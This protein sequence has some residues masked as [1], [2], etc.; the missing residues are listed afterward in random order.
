MVA[1]MHLPHESA[2]TTG[3]RVRSAR[4]AAGLSREALAA[5][6]GVALRT[7]ARIELGEDMRLGTLTS[8]ARALDVSV[9]DL[10]ADPVEAGR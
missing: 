7:L 10:V 9:V 8:I 4:E 3:D 1:D 2:T 6:A 5:R